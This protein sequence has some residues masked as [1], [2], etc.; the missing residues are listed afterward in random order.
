MEQR[1]PGQMYSN[2]GQTVQEITTP[3]KQ[4]PPETAIT[5]YTVSLEIVSPI[6]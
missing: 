1:L 4:F 2:G 6:Y 5:I 3:G